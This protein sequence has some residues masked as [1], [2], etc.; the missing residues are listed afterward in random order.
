MPRF[1]AKFLVLTLLPFMLLVLLIRAQPY[2]D[3]DLPA[4]FAPTD[5]Q[6]PCFM[7]IH[8]GVTHLDEAVAAL[9][10]QA[11]VQQVGDFAMTLSDN[12]RDRPGTIS[13]TWSGS[14]P[15]WIDASQPGVLL[16]QAGIVND[17]RVQSVIRLGELRLALGQPESQRVS[18]TVSASG[19]E[20]LTYAAIYPNQHL[21]ISA[22]APCPVSQPF[23]A[24][25]QPLFLE[26]FDSAH[27]SLNPSSA[28][29]EVYRPC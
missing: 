13:W 21:W 29:S 24:F 19:K 20:S 23:D 9:K 25:Q 8:P 27:L 17:I 5:C 4:L 12:F 7:N 22:G 6:L 16:I 15:D 11:W 26:W 28:W 14:Q 2:D 10:A 3:H 18:N 1:Y